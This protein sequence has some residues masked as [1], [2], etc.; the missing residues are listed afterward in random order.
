MTTHKELSGKKF[1]CGMGLLVDQAKPGG[2]GTIDDGNRARRFFKDPSHTTCI[3]GLSDMLIRRCAVTLQTLSSGHTVN[4][5][6]CDQHAKETAGLLVAEY[7]RYCMPA[8]VHKVLLR[9]AQ[10]VAEAIHPIGQQSEEA[11]D[12]LH[13]QL[14]ACRRVL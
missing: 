13:K 10:V 11:Q 4:I 8:S 2:C 5:E 7:P 9:G 6:A 14:Q 1:I 3:S 12:S